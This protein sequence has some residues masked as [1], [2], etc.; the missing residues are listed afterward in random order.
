MP[1]AS[2]V[3]YSSSSRPESDADSIVDAVEAAESAG[4]VYVSDEEPGIQRVKRG[5][6]FTYRGPDGST[7]SD[8]KT[9]A[10]IR[11]LAIPPAYTDV[12]ICCL[13]HGHTQATG[14]DAKGRK[15]YRYHERWREVRDSTKFEHMLEFGAALPKIRKRV[16][17]D[18]ARPG[19][20]REKVLATIVSLLEN[21]LI[22]VGNSDYAKSNKSYG[23]TT[24]KTSTWTSTETAFFS[25]SKGR[26]GKSG[27]C[28]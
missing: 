12:W 1:L 14:S 8:A 28:R 11:K 17:A 7:I 10:R 27:T 22:R 24:S 3:Q 18:L 23:L 20:P 26:A 2:S 21:T 5:K 25:N 6:G 19:L 4:L 13:E 16:A 9:L 15:Q